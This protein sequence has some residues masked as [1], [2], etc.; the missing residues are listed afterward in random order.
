VEANA[1][2]DFSTLLTIGHSSRP[3]DEF[4]RMLKAHSVALVADVRTVPKSRHNPQYGQDIMSVRLSESGVDY[5]HLKELGGLRRPRPESIN[6]GWR[7]DSFRGYAD[8]MQ[9]EDFSNGLER[10]I[11]LGRSRRV[12]IMCAE[13]VPWRCYRSLIADALLARGVAVEHIMSVTR[14]QTH[15]LTPFAC[16][17]GVRVTYP[18]EPLLLE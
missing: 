11:A 16:V 18:G 5:V 17:E 13:S 6:T 7:N 4:L 12:A 9:T 3:F 14:T 15:R 1:A 2:A 10:L 8:Y